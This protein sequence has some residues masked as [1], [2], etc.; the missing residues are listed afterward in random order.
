[1]PFLVCLEGPCHPALTHPHARTLSIIKE[2]DQEVDEPHGWLADPK[3]LFRPL[4]LIIRNQLFTF[5]SSAPLSSD[6]EKNPKL[7][8][9]LTTLILS[10]LIT[11]QMRLASSSLFSDSMGSRTDEYGWYG[12]TNC[13][14]YNRSKAV[15]HI[16]AVGH[17]N[18]S[19]GCTSPCH[20][21]ID[22][23]SP[24]ISRGCHL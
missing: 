5:C 17:R 6:R 16:I 24:D 10:K 1:M 12:S 9:L 4:N 3:T 21:I 14:P 23:W 19:H 8:Y 7:M 11:P 20:R 22:S 15:L 2:R 13:T 18:T